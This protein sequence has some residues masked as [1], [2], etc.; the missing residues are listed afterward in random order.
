MFTQHFREKNVKRHVNK[1][2]SNIKK[3]VV[4]ESPPK[5]VYALLDEE[6]QTKD[7]DSSPLGWNTW[8]T[9]VLAVDLVVSLFHL[10]AVFLFTTRIVLSQVQEGVFPPLYLTVLLLSIFYKLNSQ[11]LIQDNTLV[12]KQAICRDY[13]YRHLL[14]DMALVL[15]CFMEYFDVECGVYRLVVFLKIIDVKSMHD[16]FEVLIRQN[17]T[18]LILWRLLSMFIVNILAA[19]L[20]ALVV[21]A[22]VD[23]QVTPNWMSQANLNKDDPC[24]TTPYVWAFY[25]G[26]TIMLTIGFGDITPKSPKEALVIA[27]V[28]MFGVTTFA[29]YINAISGLLVSLREVELAKQHNLSIINRYMRRDEVS[30]EVQSQVKKAVVRISDTS[31]IDEVHE[32][33]RIIATIVPDVRDKLLQKVN[34]SPLMNMPFWN[35][36]SMKTIKRLAVVL[37]RKIYYSTEVLVTAGTV[38]ASLFM[39]KEGF[40]ESVV[41]RPSGE[42]IVVDQYSQRHFMDTKIF[43]WVLLKECLQQSVSMTTVK[44]SGHSIVMQIELDRTLE[45]LQH[46]QEDYERYCHFRDQRLSGQCEAHQKTC[47][48]CPLTDHSMLACPFYH[49]IPNRSIVIAKYMIERKAARPKPN[50]DRKRKYS[51][52]FT[53]F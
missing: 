2:V 37:D 17:R 50:L 52:C 35:R 12:R 31:K 28:E 3:T 45:V 8:R 24:W 48:F 11:V 14:V 40:V 9:D 39:L 49:F 7:R 44:S 32:E 1:F 19:H 21:I 29:Y 13:L 30:P 26:T 22:M 51:R 53:S 47:Q 18:G 16:K 46:N 25:W 34:V 20:I 6:V 42:E 41:H 15:L 5:G 27:F 33:N 23:E 10:A 43:Q 4:K 38:P 36:I